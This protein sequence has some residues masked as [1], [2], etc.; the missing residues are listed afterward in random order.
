MLLIKDRYWPAATQNILQSKTDDFHLQ[1][2][3]NQL[4][5][6]MFKH[7]NAL[8]YCLQDEHLNGK[9]QHLK[10]QTF[11]CAFSFK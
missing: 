4:P 5:G 8:E 7:S 6:R 2:G 9:M 1:T 10:G 11:D 3:Q